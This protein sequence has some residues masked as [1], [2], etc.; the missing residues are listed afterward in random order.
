MPGYKYVEDPRLEPE[1]FASWLLTQM[2]RCDLIIELA[3]AALDVC[4]FL[5]SATPDTVH[6]YLR[7]KMSDPD[8]FRIIDDAVSEC[9][10]L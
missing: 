8:T 4:R 1:P 7:A 10:V 6:A 2:E 9:S 3:A 5:T